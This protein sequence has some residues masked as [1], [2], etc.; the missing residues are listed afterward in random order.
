MTKKDEKPTAGVKRHV[1]RKGRRGLSKR[2]AEGLATLIETGSYTAAARVAK[3]DPRNASRYFN[4]QEAHEEMT[5]CLLEAGVSAPKIAEVVAR[6]IKATRFVNDTAADI[7]LKYAKDSRKG[8]MY[9][10]DPVTN[11]PRENSYGVQADIRTQKEGVELAAKL[12]RLMNEDPEYGK[13]M[14]EEGA[15]QNN[16]AW[17]RLL[18][19][20]KPTLTPEQLALVEEELRSK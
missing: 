11:L 20:L 9:F 14:Y 5:R 19:R 7:A 10:F 17:L 3:I 15:R 4:T 8:Q 16:E 1:A 12:L 18:G 6:M 13:K 2:K